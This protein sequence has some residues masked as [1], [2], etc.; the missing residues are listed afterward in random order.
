MILAREGCTRLAGRRVDESRVAACDLCVTH[1]SAGGI[2][3][4]SEALE[5][6]E[7]AAALDAATTS[8]LASSAGSFQAELGNECIAFRWGG[9]PDLCCGAHCV[10]TS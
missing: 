5:V 7:K 6:I 2:T 9:A 8:A 1:P 10:A 4:V 3:R